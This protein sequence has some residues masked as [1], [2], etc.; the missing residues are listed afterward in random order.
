[1]WYG[2][3]YIKTY[4]MVSTGAQYFC[5]L[6]TRTVYSNFQRCCQIREYRHRYQSVFHIQIQHFSSA[7]DPAPIP[8]P[9]F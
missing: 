1:V 7:A 6:G 2:T 5:F 4:D 3:L 9:Y 8:N